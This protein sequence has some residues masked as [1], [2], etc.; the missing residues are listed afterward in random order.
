M[1]VV[2]SID[3]LLVDVEIGTNR[4]EVLDH[5]QE[6]DEGPPKSVNR[7][8]HDNIEVSAAGVLEHPIQAGAILAALSAYMPV[9]W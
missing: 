8:G 5:P 2:V 6:V 4:L 3:R 9:S 1:G 7:P